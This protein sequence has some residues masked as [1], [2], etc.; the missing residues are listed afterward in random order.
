MIFLL[1]F[2]FVKPH[3]KSSK[4]NISLVNV[5]SEIGKNSLKN[6]IKNSNIAKP[7]LSK[8]LNVRENFPL[9]NT[10]K[11]SNLIESVSKKPEASLSLNKENISYNHL[12][13]PENEKSVA[14]SAHAVEISGISNNEAARKLDENVSKPI[15]DFYKPNY[16]N[17]SSSYSTEV[18]MNVS[19]SDIGLRLN[20]ALILLKSGDTLTAM[21]QMRG[22]ARES[23][24]FI[25][26]WHNLA[27]E[28]LVQHD[29]NNAY[30]CIIKLD[31]LA[32][33][34]RIKKKLDEILEL[35]KENKLTEAFKKL[36]GLKPEEE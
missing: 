34:K 14:I 19:D 1:F 28:Y 32:N 29:K 31:K 26:V 36:K 15:E 27:L 2:I 6:A 12:G 33:S 5:N 22:I 7:K 25:A 17:S 13:A 23:K 3:L 21:D 35:T 4:S 18:V 24:K 8:L 10:K 9:S 11:N 20:K 30:K 16:P